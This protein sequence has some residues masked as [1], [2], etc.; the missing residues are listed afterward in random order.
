[1]ARWRRRPVRPQLPRVR[2][3]EPVQNALARIVELTRDWERY[4]GLVDR[5]Q[6]DDLRRAVLIEM[7]V[8]MNKLAATV[9]LEEMIR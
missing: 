2:D 8:E 4:G 3:P 9:G 6:R 5:Q 7:R 1:M